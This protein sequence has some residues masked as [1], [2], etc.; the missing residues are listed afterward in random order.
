MKILEFMNFNNI[1][2]EKKIRGAL[3]KSHDV[4]HRYFE[5]Q[6]LH[7]NIN[8]NLIK[9]S[10]LIP[11][12]IKDDEI[13]ILLTN[14]SVLL[15]DHAGQISFPGG[16]IENSDN[17]PVDTAIRESYEEVG[18]QKSKVESYSIICFSFR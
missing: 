13:K 7:K 2:D 1:I 18:T 10:V 15:E 6:C 12:I 3:T 14:R 9:A 16:R 5:D 17:S 4:S 11:L 8:L